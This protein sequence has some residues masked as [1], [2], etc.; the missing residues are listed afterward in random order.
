MTGKLPL[1]DNCKIDESIAYGRRWPVLVFT[2]GHWTDEIRN[3]KDH[4]DIIAR[5]WGLSMVHAK[6]PS[7]ITGGGITVRVTPKRYTV[8]LTIDGKPVKRWFN[9]HSH[10]SAAHYIADTLSPRP[11]TE[12]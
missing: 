6:N 9:N 3:T 8:T 2:P 11:N 5:A 1:P 12:D 7:V 10:W 4:N